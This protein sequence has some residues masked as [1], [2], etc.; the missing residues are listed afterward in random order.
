MLPRIEGTGAVQASSWGALQ[1]SQCRAP[2]GGSIKLTL[3]ASLSVHVSFPSCVLEVVDV[4]TIGCPASV[5]QVIG[6]E[7]L[8]ATSAVVVLLS[9]FR[10]HPTVGWGQHL[11][12]ELFPIASI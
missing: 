1:A 7:H 10:L 2:K 11:R 5:A 3:D 8:R 9:F 12:P 6:A 4:S